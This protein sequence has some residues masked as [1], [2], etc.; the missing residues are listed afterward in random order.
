VPL[1]F[2]WVVEGRLAAS[3]QPGVGSYFEGSLVQDL[4]IFGDLGIGLI[5]TLTEQ[6]LDRD[7]LGLSNLTAV[8]LPV[9][10]MTPPAQETID[11]FLELADEAES[12]GL[13]TL[14]HCRAGLGRTGTLV[15][16]YLARGRLTADEAISSVRQMRPGSIETTE[17]E[18][19]VRV[20]VARCRARQQ[21]A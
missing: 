21:Q 6:P 20:Y 18:M 7:A 13:A 2:S 3:G 9:A 14:V 11:Q 10:D 1:N 8:H 19:A 5:V 16:C 12:Q 15:A 4:K 17:Q